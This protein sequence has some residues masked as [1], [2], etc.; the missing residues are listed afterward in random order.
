MKYAKSY[1]K[2]NRGVRDPYTGRT[3]KTVIWPSTKKEKIIPVAPKFPKG[4]L[5]NFQF[6]AYDP[7]MDETVII[8]IESAYHLGDT[9]DLISFHEED[10]KILNQ[11]Q[12]RTN[13]QYEVSAKSWTSD[14]V[15]VIGLRLYVVATPLTGESAIGGPS[16]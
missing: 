12:I 2:K 15:N 6:W 9:L 14:V 10:I 4:V 3:I 8:T 1:V 5:K 11:N 16:S 7:K 13:E